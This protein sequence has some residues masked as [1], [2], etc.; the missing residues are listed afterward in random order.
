MRWVNCYLH[1]T[2]WF[3]CSDWNETANRRKDRNVYYGI[4]FMVL[5]SWDSRKIYCRAISIRYKLLMRLH[6]APGPSA[7]KTM[8]KIN[9]FWFPR[10]ISDNESVYQVQF[11]TPRTD[12]CIKCDVFSFLRYIAHIHTM[13]KCVCFTVNQNPMTG[14]II[15][16]YYE[17]ICDEHCVC[18]VSSV[19][20]CT[21]QSSRTA[22]SQV[23]T[24]NQQ[25]Y[26]KSINL[27]AMTSD[28]SSTKSRTI[29]ISFYYFLFPCFKFNA[30]SRH[31][32]T[33]ASIMLKSEIGFLFL[34][35]FDKYVSQVCT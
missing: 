11:L 21:M 8:N 30:F 3:A 29:R 34:F 4:C 1:Y 23:E 26:L 9:N 24:I 25:F 7:T 6:V 20:Y 5:H 13:F 17:K 22:G 12:I 18:S 2:M 32:L 35:I 28:G 16:C 10:H 15:I 27:I 19:E 14:C 33:F 31:V